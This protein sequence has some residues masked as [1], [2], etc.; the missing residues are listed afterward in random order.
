MN[1]GFKLRFMIEVQSS[2]ELAAVQHGNFYS[3]YRMI[4]VI[5]LIVLI[6]KKNFDQMNCFVINRNL[7][8]K[9]EY[10]PSPATASTSIL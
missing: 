2:F 9:N 7:V 3:K 6:K 5:K 4:L 1:R 8:K 10:C